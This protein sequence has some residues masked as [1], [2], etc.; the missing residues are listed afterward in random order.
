[1]PFKKSFL[2]I[3]RVFEGKRFSIYVPE[4]LVPE[5]RG[6]LSNGRRVQDLVIEAGVRYTGL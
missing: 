1:V 2:F 3:F 6:A 5:V 4:E